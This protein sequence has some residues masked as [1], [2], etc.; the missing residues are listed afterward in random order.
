MKRN[1]LSANAASI[2]L[3]E[4]ETSELEHLAAQTGVDTRGSWEHPMD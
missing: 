2:T 4:D 1:S 3:T